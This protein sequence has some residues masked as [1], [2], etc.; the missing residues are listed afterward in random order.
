MSSNTAMKKHVGGVAEYRS[1]EGKTV[2]VPYKGPVSLII[3]RAPPPDPRVTQMRTPYVAYYV[4][5]VTCPYPRLGSSI[6]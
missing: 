4:T 3:V 6:S 1:S 5:C 2:E